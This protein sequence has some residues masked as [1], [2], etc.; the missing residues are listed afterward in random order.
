MKKEEIKSTKGKSVKNTTQKSQSSSSRINFLLI[1]FS[2]IPIYFSGIFQGGYFPWETYLTFLLSLTAIFL[3]ILTKFRAEKDNFKPLIRKSGADLGLLIFAFVAF[4]SLFFTVY[5]HATLTEFF[6]VLINLSLF[7]IILNTVENTA[8]RKNYFEFILNAV[9]VLSLILSLLG[10]LAYL[11][12]T[13]HLS[14]KFFSFLLQ[15]GFSDAAGRVSSTLQYPNTF[16]AFLILP[17]FVSFSFFLNKEE[18]FKKVLYLILALFFLLMFVF[19]QS[20]GAMIVFVVVLI[21]YILLLKG[22]DRKST[23]ISLIM[24]ILGILV[25]VLVRRDIFIPM[26]KSLWEKFKV[27]FSFFRGNWEESLGDRV[28]MIKDS[29]RILKDYPVL[30]TGNGTYQYIYM[31]YRTIYFFSKFPHS[32]FFQT[33]DELG[34]LGGAAFIYMM[35]LLFRKGFQVIKENYSSLLIGLYAGLAGILLHAFIDFDWSLMFMPMLFFYLFGVLISQ[36]KIEYFTFKCPI[37]ERKVVTQSVIQT[38]SK[39]NVKAKTVEKEKVPS[40][41]PKT[42][43]VIVAIVLSVVFLFQFIA[44]YTNHRATSTMGRVS[45]Q[46]TTSLYKTAI[47]FD[48][49]CAEYH[50]DLANFDSTY[51][52]PQIS[53][54]Q[55]YVQ[56]AETHFKAAIK[57]CS[58]FFRYHFELGNLYLK[59]GNAKA[60]DEFAK[61]VEL[62]PLD[63][64]AHA[65]LGFAYLRLK[66]NTI[67]AQTQFEIGQKLDPQNAE[68]YV[69]LGSLYE[70][71]NEPDKALENYNLA[72][73]YDSKNSYAYYRAGAIYEQKG[74]LPEAVNNLF[75]AVQYGP[76][77]TDAKTEF[78]KY[79]PLIT[80]LKPQSNESIKKGSTYD[81]VWF[82]SNNKNVEYYSIWLIPSSGDWIKVKYG[83]PKDVTAYNWTVPDDL[84]TGSYK[85]RIYAVAP[86][87][88]QGKFGNWLSYQEVKVNI[89]E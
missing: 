79:A 70:A 56:E 25:V 3:F 49:L 15:N 77:L 83:V 8:D 57:H 87:F 73:K 44:A 52:V 18:L 11:G 69:G 24:L 42:V 23:L 48:T 45:W 34:I 17:F 68:V 22:K 36:G 75:Y 29:L 61:T 76:T 72:I 82:P 84:P 86:K 80:I 1:I 60:I 89:A 39:A 62:N 66:N 37:R 54:P 31:K 81:I 33:L 10:F 20:R 59:T 21:L 67:M 4:L 38:K 35:V 28:Y 9:L 88:M 65:A 63:A 43:L 16:G 5:F 47:A 32:I 13:F 71:L 26:I 30:G 46:Q 12:S 58:T 51:L 2:L 19:T 64:G 7:Y 50:F 78:E 14:N 40:N 55:Q 27:L 41:R 6:K 53:S 85:I 74:M